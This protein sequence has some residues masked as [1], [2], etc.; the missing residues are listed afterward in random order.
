MRKVYVVYEECTNPYDKWV[1][2]IYTSN[3]K[4]YE[5][6]NTL[7]CDRPQNNYYVETEILQ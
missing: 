1:S 6:M 7:K 2:G 3:K 4:A 5:R